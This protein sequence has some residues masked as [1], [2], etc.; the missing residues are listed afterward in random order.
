M[1][2]NFNKLKITLSLIILMMLTRPSS[3]SI[4]DAYLGEI[5]VLVKGA[6][7]TKDR[8]VESLVE[9]CL[10]KENYKSWESIDTRKLEQ[11]IGNSRLFEQVEVRVNKPV[12]DVTV[13][14]RWTL[15]PVPIA[16]A[17]NGKRSI[18]A[19]IVDSNFLGYGKTMGVGG[20]VSTDGNTFT[21]FYRDPSVNF[22]NVTIRT[23]VN[24]SAG[25]FDH[26]QGNNIIYGYKKRELSVFFSPGYRITPSLEL[27][28]LL[29]YMDRRY[30]KIDPYTAIPGNYWSYSTGARLS[31]ANA[32]YKLYYN[33]GISA[34]I[35]WLRQIHRSDESDNVSQT[36]ARF[37]WDTL[38]V[39][40]HALQLVLNTASL[41][42]NGNAGDILM[43]GRVNGYRGINPNGLWTR[44]ITTMSLDYQI[45]VKK[46]VH[47]IFTVAPFMDYG[48]YDPVSPA[49]GSNYAAYG[50]GGYFFVNAINL[51][52]VIGLLIGRNEEFLGNFI[53]FQFG[54]GY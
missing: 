23:S 46:V 10:E 24:Q 13:E 50:V 15:I 49:T 44:R 1:I 51:P 3:S 21:L 25:E 31:Y 48:I 53:S 41:T 43:F 32:D 12:I 2:R 18:G 30:E 35:L 22:G 52:G 9:K 54:Y 14:D 8:T 39:D 36:S 42:D 40:Q 47:G 16:Y 20:A 5:N 29:N 19:F 7:R 4:T 34:Q 28:A 17:V 26:Y 6:I 11:C 38:L 33:D 37:E 45:P 27:S